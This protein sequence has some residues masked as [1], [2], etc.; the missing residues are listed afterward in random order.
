[1][2]YFYRYVGMDLPYADRIRSISSKIFI[3]EHSAASHDTS[4]FFMVSPRDDGM[5]VLPSLWASL[6]KFVPTCSDAYVYA[7]W[8]LRWWPPPLRHPKADV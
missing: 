8:N 5:I 1:M 6:N 4:S 2:D 7:D 3:A